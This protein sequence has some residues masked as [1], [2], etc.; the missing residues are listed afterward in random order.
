MNCRSFKY[1]IALLLTAGAVAPVYAKWLPAESKSGVRLLDCRYDRQYLKDA[2][3]I[4]SSRR[5]HVEPSQ[6]TRK[7]V[8]PAL[9]DSATAVTTTY[10]FIA[11]E[12]ME[13]SGVAIAHDFS[14]WSS[15]NYV[16]IPA[17]VY[18]GNRQRIVN[19]S[20]AT[21]LDPAD[22]DRRDLAL[23]SNPIPQLN[24]DFGAPSLLEVSVCNTA[25]PAI[26]ILDRRGKEAII[27]LTEQG[28]PEND[29][30]HDHALIVEE[31]PDRSAATAVISAP[32][33]RE[34]KPQFIGFSE[35]PDR[36]M[37]FTKGDTV[38]ISVTEVRF[39]ARSTADL[40][41][42]FM[43][44][45][46]LHTD[47]TSRLPRNFYPMSQVLKVMNEN[48]DNR[49]F[50]NDSVEF[51]RPEGWDWMSYGWIGGMINTYPMIALGDAEHLRKVSRTFDFG[52]PQGKGAAGYYYD[53]LKPDGTVEL[54]DACAIVPG[55][56]LTRKNGDLLY[57]MVKQL[58]LLKAT[59]HE[60][61]INPMW[62]E[63]TRRLAD[64][65]LNTWEKYGTWGGYI[66]VETGEPAT[67]NTSGGSSAVAGMALASRYFADSRYL[68]A[69]REAADNL[70]NNFSV[71]GFT[72]GGCGDILQNADSE[73]AIALATAMVSLYETTGERKY[74]TMGER[75]A[76]LCA[77][78]TVS[79]D[80]VLPPDL[81]LAK[82]GANMMGAVWAST[83]N[84]HGAPGFCT[85]SGDALFKLY[86][87][88]GN[89]DYAELLR[90]IIHAHAEGI[91]PDGTINERLTYC[92]ADSRGYLDP[93]WKTGWNETNG[94]LMA[95]EI[96]GIYVKGGKELMVFDHAEARVLKTN[97]NKVTLEITNPTKMDA[98]YTVLAE[99]DEAAAKPLGDN[100]FVSRFTPVSVK[101]GKTKRVTLTL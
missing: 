64:A 3:Q 83:Q 45:R 2:T 89:R 95:L 90:D 70:Y 99:T 18:N 68:K 101:A 59:G 61:R 66:H 85:L 29:A 56:G 74:L 19:R 8:V 79:F 53:L 52:L 35:S 93:N 31:S 69:A 6:S 34:K 17:S 32:G 58:E 38:T 15:D 27:L 30:I 5:W 91:Q 78:W 21:G 73:T 49:Y 50:V 40:L 100:A 10:Q 63:E 71:V 92:D 76:D 4:E 41:A 24:P 39:P 51:Y 1:A 60:D 48:I 36:A 87:A 47:A 96:P 20:Y 94:A 86:R 7:F 37:N 22:Y 26:A 80:Y 57:W 12:D 23:T 75:L 28:I 98:T 88:G 9:G 16:M 72:S 46:K 77:T 42:G 11:L 67:Y 65:F 81:M 55:I 13:Q 97:G 62:V 44:T 82:T 25:T 43:N 54:R 14:D 84:K 33:V